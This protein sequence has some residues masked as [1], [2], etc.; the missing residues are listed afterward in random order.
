MVHSDNNTIIRARRS[1][2]LVMITLLSEATGEYE[3]QYL[4][5]DV[6]LIPTNRF[7]LPIS[8]DS[9][10]LKNRWL[11]ANFFLK[12][13]W[14]ELKIGGAVF[15]LLN[16]ADLLTDFNQ[17]LLSSMFDKIGGTQRY[18]LCQIIILMSFCH[19]L[20]I[21]FTTHMEYQTINV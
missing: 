19:E 17:Q 20:F 3:T 9:Q 8:K 18:F 1:D 21:L 12:I 16:P 11:S 5:V 15:F 2:S 10:R 7:F 4:V 14:C 13:G 6:S